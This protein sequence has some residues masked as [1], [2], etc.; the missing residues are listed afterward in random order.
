MRKFLKVLFYFVAALYPVLVFTFLVILKIPARLLSLCVI[1]LAAAF[2]LS[3]T[4]SSGAVK[5]K[6]GKKK[7]LMN[8]RPLFSSVLFLAA[9]I[10]CFAFNQKVF[11]KLYSVAVNA[12]LLIVF[13]STL[14]FKPNIIF[15][16]ATLADKSIKGSSFEANVEKYC[17]KVTVVWCIF[18][19]INGSIAAY[20][21]LHDFGSEMLNDRVWSVYN[22]GISYVIM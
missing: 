4:G 5:G 6:D 10:L 7:F 11:L 22:G 8:W 1:A 3:F 19:I 14:F 9:G 16:F 2:F 17:R 15:R 20:T 12:T 13:G 21:A 18:F